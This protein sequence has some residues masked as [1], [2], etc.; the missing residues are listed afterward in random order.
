MILD[1]LRLR[2]LDDPVARSVHAAAAN[3]SQRGR[4]RAAPAPPRFVGDVVDLCLGDVTPP[5]SAHSNASLTALARR[6]GL[7]PSALA[8]QLVGRL[9]EVHRSKTMALGAMTK[10]ALQVLAA[11]ALRRQAGAL[12]LQGEGLATWFRELGVAALKQVGPAA[13]GLLLPC[14]L[15]ES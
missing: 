3:Q 12:G 2:H 9:F 5:G 11:G 8:P 4:R 13:D 6:L 7:A 15:E 1:Y 14:K 10:Q